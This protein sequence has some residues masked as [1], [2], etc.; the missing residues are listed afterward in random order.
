MNGT[1]LLV[2]GSRGRSPVMS[3]GIISVATDGTMCPGVDSAS[4][5]E[6]QEAPEGKDGLCVRATTL[7]PSYCGK[8]RKS[9]ALTYRIPKGMLRP[10]A[11]EFKINKKDGW[12]FWGGARPGARAR[13]R[14]APVGE[15]IGERNED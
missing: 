2:G 4:K 13:G 9:G 8:S 12:D 1:A 15:E 6:Y 11:G 7:P 3:L 10:V 5:Y 14:A